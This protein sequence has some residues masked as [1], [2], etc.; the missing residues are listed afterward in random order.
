M[1]LGSPVFFMFFQCRNHNH[2]T[3]TPP[4]KPHSTSCSTLCHLPIHPHICA[5]HPFIHRSL[6]FTTLPLS[7]SVVGL[8]LLHLSNFYLFFPP[9]LAFI[10]IILLITLFF[11]C[12]FLSVAPSPRSPS[13]QS[14]SILKTPPSLPPPPKITT[15]Y[16]PNDN[17]HPGSDGL[18]L[19]VFSVFCVCMYM[20]VCVCECISVCCCLLV[21]KP[22]T[23]ISLKK[24]EKKKHKIKAKNCQ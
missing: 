4:S 3:L 22:I 23:L 1:E 7:P 20:Y 14:K 24:K 5:V 10:I 16:L 17:I 12:F 18:K 13:F 21:Y 8:F 2:N 11:C 19:W 6:F 15:Y 9:P